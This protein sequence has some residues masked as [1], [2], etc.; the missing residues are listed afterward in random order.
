MVYLLN[1]CTYLRNVPI[2]LPPS[3]IQ[4]LTSPVPSGYNMTCIPHLL[5][6]YGALLLS[7]LL[8]R[9]VVYVPIHTIYSVVVLY[10]SLFVLLIGICTYM[11]CNCYTTFSLCIV[12]IY[13]LH[14]YLYSISR[15]VFI[16]IPKPVFL[17]FYSSFSHSSS[18]YIAFLYFIV[19]YYIHI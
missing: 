3:F 16:C 9:H 5:Q 18:S 10:H 17:H 13:L 6:C 19:W 2:L 12:F 15:D 8:I 7:S 4:L 11:C 1:L 14:T